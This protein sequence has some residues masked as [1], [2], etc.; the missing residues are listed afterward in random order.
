MEEE[1]VIINDK[2]DGLLKEFEEVLKKVLPVKAN[3]DLVNQVIYSTLKEETK[4]K[5][6]EELLVSSKEVLGWQTTDVKETNT[7]DT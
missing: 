4:E 5:V 3:A 1:K 7:E 2:V 6:I